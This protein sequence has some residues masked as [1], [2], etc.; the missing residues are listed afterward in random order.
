MEEIRLQKV[1]SMNGI[2]SRRKAEEL[3]RSGLVTVNG[4][5]A[6]IGQKV[7]L[8]VDAVEID[9]KPIVIS[10]EEITIMMNKPVKC[11]TTLYDSAHRR[12]I[13]DLLPQDFPRVFPVG[14]LDYYSE[15]LLLLTNNGDLAYFFT[16]PSHHIEK[17]YRV[18]LS[19]DIENAIDRLSQPMVI[20]D[21]KIHQPAL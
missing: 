7:N 6:V 14:R 4:K 16:H 21:Y 12:T 10:N 15:G 3:I 9:G 19:G 18:D 8:S 13:K 17:T 11:L 1:L 2:S 20:D 5:T